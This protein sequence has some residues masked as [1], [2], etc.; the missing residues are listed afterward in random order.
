MHTNASGNWAHYDLHTDR[1][2]FG[3][4]STVLTTNQGNAVVSNERYY[5]YG[6]T[7]Y[8]GIGV[9]DHR[10]TGQKRDGTGLQYYNAR[11]YD[12]DLG[13]FLSPDT[14][15]P[16]PTNLFDYNRYMYTRG[17]PMRYNDPTGHCGID[18][19][20]AAVM[21]AEPFECSSGGGAAA[22][23]AQ[24]IVDGTSAT[25]GIATVANTIQ[26]YKE[27]VALPQPTKPEVNGVPLTDP[28]ADDKSTTTVPAVPSQQVLTDP[29][30]GEQKG[31]NVVYSSPLGRGSTGRTAPTSLNE[32]LA[33]E[34]AMSNPNAGRPVPLKKG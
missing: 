27:S 31:S 26:E 15:V 10:F 13:Q 30:D 33:M 23:L 22:A 7:R 9:T 4:G 16:D 19:G 18:S 17:N 6:R 34:E 14:I 20:V 21:Q 11:Y 28:L 12:P 24:L 1:G 29:L 32:Q 2:P 8:G 5:A 3:R 25:I